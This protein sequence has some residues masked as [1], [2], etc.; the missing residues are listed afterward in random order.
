METRCKAL[1][2]KCILCQ[3]YLYSS[4][5][6]PQSLSSSDIRKILH[7]WYT[8]PES[9]TRWLRSPHIHPHLQKW[10]LFTMILSVIL[11]QFWQEKLGYVYTIAG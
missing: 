3:L 8:M 10:N 11:N 6:H 2:R 4:V 1:L 7:C 5:H 9:H